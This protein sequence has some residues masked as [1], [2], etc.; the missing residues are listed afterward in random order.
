M[1][2]A[3]TSTCFCGTGRSVSHSQRRIEKVASGRQTT[4]GDIGLDRQ[5]EEEAGGEDRPEQRP[6]RRT[7]HDLQILRLG[8]KR[9]GDQRLAQAGGGIRQQVAPFLDVPAE[10][11]IVPQRVAAAHDRNAAGRIKTGRQPFERSAAV[12][13]AGVVLDR[14]AEVA[15]QIDE[16]QQHAG[17]ENER[18]DRG[19][20]C[21]STPAPSPADRYRPAAA[22]P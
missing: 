13:I 7:R 8:P 14:E 6:R 18:A 11:G 1:I 16:E 9:A 2:P 5:Q 21:W 19:E 4:A 20:Q 10:L 15:G 22:C 3:P 17:A 12:G